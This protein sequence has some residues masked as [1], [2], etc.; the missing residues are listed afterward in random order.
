MLTAERRWKRRGALKAFVRGQRW[1]EFGRV[2][3]NRRLGG[4]GVLGCH[5]KY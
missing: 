5:Q 2:H 1:P 4:L 3:V